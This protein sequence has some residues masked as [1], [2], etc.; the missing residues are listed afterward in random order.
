[1][2]PD[3]RVFLERSGWADATIETIAGDLSA[4]SYFRLEKGDTS[5][6]LM[7]DAKGRATSLPKFVDMTRWLRGLGLSAPE[8]LT[9]DR[10]NGFLLLEDLGQVPVSSLLDGS[11]QREPLDVCIDLLLTIRSAT[12]PALPC[13]SAEEL[14]DWTRIADDY[15]PGADPVRLDRFRAVLLPALE[16][17]ATEK[18]TV[19]LRDFHADNLMWLPDRSG[20]ARLGLLDYQDA[21]LAHPVYDLVSLLTDART[22]ITMQTREHYIA[23]YAKASGDDPSALVEAFATFSLQ[24]NLRILGIFHRAAVVDG[25]THHLPKIP[26]VYRYVKEALAHPRFS[27]LRAELPKALPAPEGMA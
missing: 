13:P 17:L 15:C 7:D 18:P 2:R 10:D 22:E 14:C 19:S 8:L 5:A 9:V 25:K 27:H 4:R 24:R 1:M 16:T 12:P 3:A 23:A 6:V 26:R 20:V 11:S 21:I